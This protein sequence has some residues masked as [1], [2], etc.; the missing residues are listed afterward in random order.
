[1]VIFFDEI[2]TSDTVKGF[3][4]E[5]IID[6]TMLGEPIDPRVSFVAACNP[7]QIIDPKKQSNITTGLDQKEL[8]KN[9]S[10]TQLVYKVFPLPESIMT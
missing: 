3:F 2:N 1:L 10:S 8:D 6:R 7:Y 4:K 5:L 9:N